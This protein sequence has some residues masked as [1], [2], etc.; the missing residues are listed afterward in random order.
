MSAAFGA[1][2]RSP[3]AGGSLSA[4][5]TSMSGYLVAKKSAP[6]APDECATIRTLDRPRARTNAAR[7]SPCV[8]AAASGNP[9]GLTSLGKW[10]RRLYAMARNGRRI[11]ANARPTSDSPE[12]AVNEDDGFALAGLHIG[13]LG[14]VGGD[15]LDVV[16]RDRGADRAGND[17]GCSGCA[18]KVATCP[19]QPPVECIGSSRSEHVK[20]MNRNHSPIIA[21][22]DL[23]NVNPFIEPL[24][25]PK[26]PS[27]EN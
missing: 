5:L 3:V 9:S 25:K 22:S 16:G 11:L 6:C 12:A 8:S 19:C 26:Y 15:P 17:Q 1:P 20:I 24:G 27:S 14:A 4:R 10:L 18:C 2:V 23:T 13:K 7:S 21:T